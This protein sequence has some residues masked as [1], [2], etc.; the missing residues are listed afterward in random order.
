MSKK[1]LFL[2][3]LNFLFFHGITAQEKKDS[4]SLR[5]DFKFGNQPLELQKKYTTASDTL[6]IDLMRFYLSD[7]QIAY[8]DASTFKEKNSYHLIDIEELNSWVVGLDAYKNKKIKTVTFA[9]GID[10]TASVSGALSGAL[11]PSKG[12]YW[13]WQSGYINMKMEGKSN[14]CTTRNNRFQFHVGGYLQPYCAWRK[15]ELHP[16]AAGTIVPIAVDLAE[17]FSNVTLSKT[18]SIMIPGKRAVEMAELST[19]MFQVE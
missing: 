11:D 18:N 16:K 10:S 15:V 17:L 4:L 12:M 3:L 9:I 1:L 19:K 13:A 2:V 8:E 5:F 14:S 7:I 6:E